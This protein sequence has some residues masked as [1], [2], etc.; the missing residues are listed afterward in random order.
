MRISA[1]AKRETRVRMLAA[2]RRLFVEQGYA[3]TSTRDL[4][5][6][7]GVAAGTLFN[8]FPTK[9]ALAMTV[10]GEALESGLE[11]FL[12][13]RR[14][15]EGLSEDLF[16]LV[17]AGLRELEPFRGFVGEVFETA[18]S[19]FARG[20][21]SSEGEQVRLQHLESVATVLAQHGRKEPPTIVAM[22][23]YWTLYLGVIAFW[24]KDES[25]KQEDTLAIL[26]QSMEL[27][28]DSI[29]RNPDDN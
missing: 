20:S 10:L 15:D 14:G 28:V 22:H 6:A 19:P 23:L 27:F 16:A 24:S 4:A 29:Q 7:S 11:G 2:A 3:A 1:E 18:M 25:P 21:V 8:Y 26:D 17:A 12:T 5:A 13:R 9:E